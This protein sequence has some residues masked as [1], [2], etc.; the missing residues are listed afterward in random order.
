[1]MATGSL[2]YLDETDVNGLDTVCQTETLKGVS[3]PLRPSNIKLVNTELS[4]FPPSKGPGFVV[5]TY[6]DVQVLKLQ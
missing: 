3:G 2:S 5:R 1:M 4:A 6:G